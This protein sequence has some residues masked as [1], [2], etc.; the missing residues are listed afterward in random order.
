MRKFYTALRT[1]RRRSAITVWRRE[2]LLPGLAGKTGSRAGN[3]YT[4]ASTRSHT[5]CAPGSN[6]DGIGSV[7][8]SL[9]PESFCRCIAISVTSAS[10]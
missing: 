8:S 3:L 2:R 5:T 10:P 6:P 7:V 1:V 9:L 4:T